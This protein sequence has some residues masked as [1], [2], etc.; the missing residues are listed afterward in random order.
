MSFPLIFANELWFKLFLLIFDP[1]LAFI[2]FYDLNKVF[3]FNDLLCSGSSLTSRL[4]LVFIDNYFFIYARLVVLLSFILELSRTLDFFWFW[5]FILLLICSLLFLSGDKKS[6]LF[7]Y[8]L[9]GDYYF[10][11]PSF[12]MLL[13]LLLLL[14][15]KFPAFLF[16]GERIN[17]C[18]IYLLNSNRSR[19]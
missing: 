8:F 4:S 2:V 11:C 3:R 6:I 10:W 17:Y 5:I 12:L 13:V 16:Y 18:F 19:A 14:L 1:I 7:V 15:K 9:I